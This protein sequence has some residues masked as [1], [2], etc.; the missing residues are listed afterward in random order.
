MRKIIMTYQEFLAALI[1]QESS[2]NYGIENPSGYLGKYQFGEG[3]LID[4]KYYLKDGTDKN[5][6]IGS[7]TGK[8]GIFSKS[9]F[10]NNPAVQDSAI[11]DY[12]QKQWEY[13]G[14][15]KVYQY[16]GQVLNGIKITIS[17]MLAGAH[18]VGHAGEKKYLNS[19]GDVVPADGNETPITQYMQQFAD[20]DTPFTID[21]SVA[22][23]INGG[24]GNDELKGLGGN[25]SLT[26]N[27]GNDTLDG[28]DGNDTLIGGTGNETLIGGDGNDDLYGGLDSV[29]LAG[30]LLV[31]GKGDDTLTG[32]IG[33]DTLMGGS[34]YDT[35]KAYNGNVIDDTNE[36]PFIAD[37]VVM[38]GQVYFNDNLLHGGT[39]KVGETDYKDKDGH[40][41]TLLGTKLL[42]TDGNNSL[43]KI[44]SFHNH[45]LGIHLTEEKGGSSD[46][47]GNG[48]IG[49]IR[50]KF[51]QAEKT[52]SP[53]VLDLNSD[54]ITTTDKLS[55]AYF[56]HDGNNFA[57]QT[58]WINNQD[59]LLV[60]DLNNNGKIDNGG[61]LFGSETL[62]QN[63]QKA[64]NGYLALAEL[65]S[66]ADKKIDSQDAAFTTLQIW[67][68]ANGDGRS[69]A[70]ELFSLVDNGIQSKAAV[71][72]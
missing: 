59:G 66:N 21:H 40:T 17:G 25:D 62:L 14:H 29:V 20:F 32:G 16:E 34:G 47:G 33:Y 54:G 61:E 13:L 50:D 27:G 5:D 36:S 19:G 12:M 70:D 4:I 38:A 39:K 48:D 9:D 10:L 37:S 68:D 45:D 23:T 43:L 49:D 30:D 26:G 71:A 15:D 58:G 2:G 53:I 35:Y 60:R 22:E 8:D 1:K 57:E 63:G 44:E 52:K 51:D 42:V 6:W 18:L 64:A 69:S 55:G 3:A 65:D 24:K 46:G 56:D 31:G 7:W 28:G 41:Y 72:Y 67:Q 11:L